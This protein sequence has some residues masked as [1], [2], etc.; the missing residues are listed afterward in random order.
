VESGFPCRNTRGINRKKAGQNTA[1][2]VK[3][4]GRRPGKRGV[5]GARRLPGGDV[6]FET[7]RILLV[8]ELEREA[9]FEVA[10]HPGLN[11]AQRNLG[12]Q[13]WPVFG[14]N[15]GLMKRYFPQPHYHHGSG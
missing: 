15:G 3:N 5:Y 11:P 7:V 1:R 9:F 6:I 2:A 14:R 13:R 12:L 8:N 4:R 10:D